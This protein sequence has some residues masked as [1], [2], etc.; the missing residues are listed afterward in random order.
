MI[1]ESRNPATGEVV[2]TFPEMEPAAIDRALREADQA[3]SRW[4]NVP[5]AERAIPLRRAAAILRGKKNEYGALMAREMGKPIT[6]GEAEAEKC[7]WACEYYAERTETILAPES[8]DTDAVRSYVRFDPLGVILAVMPWNF[9]FWQVFSFVAPALMAGNAGL[10]KHASNVPRCALSIEE[11]LRQAGFP[12]GLFRSL[13]ISSRPVEGILTSPIVKA[14]TLTGSEAA[15]STV[16]AIAGRMCKKTVLELGGSDPFIVLDDAD[17]PVA[18]SWAA[19]AR[20]INT[21]QSCIA[22]KR[23][24]VMEGVADRFMEAFRAELERLPVGDP[25]DPATRVGPMAR[26]DLLTAL[27]GQVEESCARGARLVTGGRRLGGPG[28]F[29]PPTLL[30]GVTPGMPAFDQET[31]GPLAAV[32]RVGTEAEA[33]RLANLSPYGLGA[34]VWSGYPKRAERLAPAIE[35]GSVFING[36][37]KSDPRLPFGGVKLSGYGRELSSYG[38]KEFVN[39]KTVWVGV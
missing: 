12:P 28:Y 30:D 23:F 2:E 27:H 10:L 17:V 32:V 9:P 21:G 22:A 11:I 15:G 19:R 8:I 39:I 38:I 34:S 35:S 7:A 36:M 24:L 13:L 16:A 37:V 25:M 20:T 26:E 18:A 33:V 6:E 14:A 29:Y 3:F 31:F 4:K 1:L 5:Y